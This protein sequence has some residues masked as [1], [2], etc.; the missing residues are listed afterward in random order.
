MRRVTSAM[1]TEFTLEMP[2][3]LLPPALLLL[4]LLLVACGDSG[5]PN[6]GGGDQG[7]TPSAGCTD[8]TLTTGALYR[9]CF[10]G[11]W[12]GEL[13]I[14]AHGYV[15]ASQPIALHDD[16]IGGQSVSSSVT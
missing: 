8:G 13:V 9:I 2:R 10:P 12:N 5:G 11:Q 15:D 16:V 7:V 1:K 14:Y 6:D 4:A 3:T